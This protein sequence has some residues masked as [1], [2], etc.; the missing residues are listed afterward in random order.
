MPRFYFEDQEHGP[1]NVDY[2]RNKLERRGR[3]LQ[4]KFE[5]QICKALSVY[6]AI[7]IIVSGRYDGYL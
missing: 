5:V 2:M 3:K 7:R 6:M 4:R 1:G